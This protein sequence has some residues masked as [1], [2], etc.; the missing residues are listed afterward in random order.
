MVG[1]GAIGC[2]RGECV[3]DDDCS[4]VTQCKD[5]ACVDPCLSGTCSSADFCRV[6]NHTPIC[7]YHYEPTTSEPKDEFVIGERYNS[8][9]EASPTHRVVIG[10][11]DQPSQPIMPSPD[12]P[13]VV[14]GSRRQQQQLQGGCARGGPGCDVMRMMMMMDTSGLPVIGASFNRKKRRIVRRKQKKEK[15]Y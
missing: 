8:G 14:G 10:S 3:E 11:R 7:G 9:T 13:F 15:K 1:N 2:Y 4:A 12:N 5:F 6:M